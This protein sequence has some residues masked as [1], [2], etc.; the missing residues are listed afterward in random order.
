MAMR[1]VACAPDTPQGPVN[2]EV[3][4]GAARNPSAVR[5]GSRCWAPGAPSVRSLGAN[6]NP[7]GMLGCQGDPG[8]EGSLILSLLWIP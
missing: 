5:M 7:D 1:R 6:V 4:W 2:A 3:G 8:E